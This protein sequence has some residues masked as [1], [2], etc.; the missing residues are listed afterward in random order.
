MGCACVRVCEKEQNEGAFNKRR[1]EKD[2]LGENF[3]DMELHLIS[4][5]LLPGPIVRINLVK[6]IEILVNMVTEL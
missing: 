5:A 6:A 3:L 1:W 2:D 4:L